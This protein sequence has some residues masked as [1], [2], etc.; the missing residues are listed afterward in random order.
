MPGQDSELIVKTTD[1]VFGF[2]FRPEGTGFRIG[3]WGL[4][5]RNLDLSA[6]PKLVVSEREPES[7]RSTKIPWI[8]NDGAL[9]KNVVSSEKNIIGGEVRNILKSWGYIHE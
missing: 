5:S 4:N 6:D 1:P 3:K 9:I 7:F 2:Q 8:Y